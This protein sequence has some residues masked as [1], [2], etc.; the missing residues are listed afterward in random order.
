M[1]YIL[2]RNK[3][4]RS[5]EWEECVEAPMKVDVIRRCSEGD[6]GRELMRE[7][8]ELANKLG[9]RGSPSWL[10]NNRHTIKGRDPESIK[11]DFCAKNEQP[12]C[13]NKLTT[14]AA[15]RAGSCG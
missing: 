5:D 10:L 3:N 7:S 8:F 4:I 15:K 1:D 9:F 6:E 12:E 11:N 13:A 2:C 14:K